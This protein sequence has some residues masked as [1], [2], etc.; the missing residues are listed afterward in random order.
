MC[1]WACESVYSAIDTNQPKQ[2]ELNN[3]C[4]KR[5]SG[6]VSFSHVSVNTVVFQNEHNF[7]CKILYTIRN[8]VNI[9]NVAT[10]RTCYYNLHT[11]IVS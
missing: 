7:L 8:M 11:R 3:W 1:M 9:I 5:K 6:T 2:K 4:E 10:V